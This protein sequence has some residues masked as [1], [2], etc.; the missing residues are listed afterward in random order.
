MTDYTFDSIK[1]IY[2]HII[3]I[4]LKLPTSNIEH[5]CSRVGYVNHKRPVGLNANR[6]IPT[7]AS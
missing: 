4:K 2:S 1:N 3:Y 6:R 5:K 7:A